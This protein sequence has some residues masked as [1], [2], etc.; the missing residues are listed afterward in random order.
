VNVRAVEELT[1]FLRSSVLALVAC[2]LFVGCG[3]NDLAPACAAPSMTCGSACVD[4]NTDNANCGAC[5]H[6]CEAGYV[7]DGT[8]TCALSC[9]SELTVCGGTCA[10][11][12]SD[13][14]NCGACG[15]VCGN[16]TRCLEGTCGYNCPPGELSCDGTCIDPY[17]DNMHCGASGNCQGISSGVMCGGGEVCNGSGVCATSCGS[18]ELD[19][20][21]TCI[22]PS[23]NNTYC[24]ATGDCQGANAG[25]TCGGGTVCAGSD[26]CQPTC[27][28]TMVECNGTCID[29]STNNN[30][31]GASGDCMGSN[32]GSA[33][34]SGY[35]CSGS[36]CVVTCPSGEIDCNGQCIDPNRDNTY[37]GATTDCVGSDA[38]SACGSGFVC[39]GSGA[40]ALTCQSGLTD[41]NGTC[42]DT[43][44]DPNNCGACGSACDAN[45]AC[46]VGVCTPLITTFVGPQN[47]VAIASL[48]GWSQCF[49]TT[50]ADTST[51]VSDVETACSGSQLMMAC[52]PTG[53]DT[54][55]LAA[56][57]GRD[58]VTFEEGT[59]DTTHNA[60]G[61]EWYFDDSYSWGFAPGGSSVERNSCDVENINSGDG[62][63]RLC[64]HT[65]SHDFFFGFRC[66]NDL[67][68]G[69]TDYE[70]IIFQAN[71]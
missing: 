35:V 20:N 45:E 9:Q 49:V 59:G 19:C 11:T 23:T 44:F 57:A 60:N 52:R 8:G 39:D 71:F 46:N 18:G 62:A 47:N 61:T 33:C 68:N 10:N 54:L 38:G 13:D 40:C 1:M 4:V 14:N 50:Y 36:A 55:Q 30:Y 17:T 5:G 3:D 70:K 56:Y 64:W 28:D 6:S 2:G 16:G 29:P 67:L 32:A 48:Q 37:C 53:S 42:T 15:N 69:A 31:C 27:Q 7:C 58:D 12:Q 25:S 34:G 22:D 63:Q 65:E 41:C 21:G 51:V 26:G 66:G 24:D 43:D